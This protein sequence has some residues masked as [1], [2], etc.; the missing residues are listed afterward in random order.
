MH[1]SL[2]AILFALTVISISLVSVLLFRAPEVSHAQTDKTA[3]AVVCPESWTS[4]QAA[5][6]ITGS[7]TL[8]SVAVISP[9]DV[10]AVGS[11][12]GRHYLRTRPFTMHW[13]GAQWTV[14]PVPD[15]G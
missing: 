6:A 11:H 9:N 15:V 10:W 1:R 7:N 2:I 14:V 4:I 8:E 5:E 3:T 13:D 12:Q